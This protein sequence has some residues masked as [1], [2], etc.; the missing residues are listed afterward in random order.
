M[1]RRMKR[2][3]CLLVGTLALAGCG[4]SSNNTGSTG[5]PA[6]PSRPTAE[7]V[8]AWP[9]A[10]CKAQPGMSRSEL[11]DLMGNP[12]QELTLES[13]PSGYEPQMRWLADGYHFTAFFD[14]NDLAR[15]LQVNDL[16]LSAQQAAA[17]RC[18]FSR[19]R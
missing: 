17:I 12:T 10:W 18:P 5:G 1:L 4:S 16:D 14:T 9:T 13:A 3:L 15:S 2:T 6:S 8:K 19:T 7:N 11:R